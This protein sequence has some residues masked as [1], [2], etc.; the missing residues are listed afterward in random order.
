MA[1]QVSL[2]SS[3]ARQGQGSS[4]LVQ[5]RAGHWHSEAVVGAG[6]PNPGAAVSRVCQAPYPQLRQHQDLALGNPRGAGVLPLLLWQQFTEPLVGT[7]RGKKKSGSVVRAGW[8]QPV[9]APADLP[10]VGWPIPTAPA[11]S[12]RPG[13]CQ[14]GVLQL[15]PGPRRGAA[16]GLQK[17]HGGLGPAPS[18]YAAGQGVTGPARVTSS[19]RGPL[20]HHKRLSGSATGTSRFGWASRRNGSPGAVPELSVPRSRGCAL[21][22]RAGAGGTG[23]QGSRLHPAPLTIFRAAVLTARSPACL[24]TSAPAGTARVSTG[25][26]AKA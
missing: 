11:N 4:L 22:D 26:G 8:Q 2:G 10:R 23:G 16:E 13:A 20:P 24:G 25:A 3:V 21:R 14:P 12:A 9:W 15:L 6:G 5:L 19:T 17:G 7:L 18:P 1:Q